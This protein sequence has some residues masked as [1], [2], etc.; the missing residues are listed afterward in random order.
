MLIFLFDPSF[1]VLP[2]TDLGVDCEKKQLWPQVYKREA[3]QHTKFKAVRNSI[4]K[5]SHISLEH[6]CTRTINLTAP[7][8]RLHLLIHDKSICTH[9]WK[10]H[11]QKKKKK[12]RITTIWCF[13]ILPDIMSPLQLRLQKILSKTTQNLAKIIPNWM[14]GLANKWLFGRPEENKNNCVM[15]QNS[16]IMLFRNIA[17][18]S[19]VKHFI[20]HCTFQGNASPFPPGPLQPLPSLAPSAALLIPTRS[21]FCLPDFPF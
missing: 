16:S 14:T 8:E 1:L 3:S 12:K 19:R 18:T 9:L 4:S 20:C 6:I 2:L 21:L 15:S 7:K 17:N 13:S 5:Y 11:M 10:V